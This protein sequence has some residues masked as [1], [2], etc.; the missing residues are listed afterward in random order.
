MLCGRL[1]FDDEYIPKLFQKINGGIYH[2]PSHLSEDARSLLKSMLVVDPVKRITTAGIRQSAWFQTN[3]PQYLQPLPQTPGLGE[4]PGG[5]TQG[6][7]VS[8]LLAQGGIGA[9][10]TGT[11]G[12]GA[13]LGEEQM[14]RVAE[15]Q[16]LVYVPDLGVVEPR[17]V[18][19]LCEKMAGFDRNSIWDALKREGD[20]QIKVAYQL[21]RDHK[22]MLQDSECVTMQ[23]LETDLLATARRGSQAD[24]VFSPG[25]DIASDRHAARQRARH[26]ELFGIVATTLERR[27]GKRE[28]S[29][30]GPERSLTRAV[31]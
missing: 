4:G 3:L 20:N 18:D 29:Y 21:V 16:G 10:P 12:G 26:G 22:R 24:M 28:S 8:A 31:D 25:H 13:E 15:T 2:L 5:Q 7:D 19:E 9:V 27:I 17:I 30:P 11:T 14:A 23:G 6:E 1:P